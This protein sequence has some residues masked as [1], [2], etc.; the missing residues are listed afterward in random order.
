MEIHLNF[1]ML[2]NKHSYKLYYFSIHADIK[3]VRC[4]RGG[5]C[6]GGGGRRRRRRHRRRLFSLDAINCVFDIVFKRMGR[7]ISPTVV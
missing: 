5:R 1:S 4:C 6:C 7:H 2:G 3:I